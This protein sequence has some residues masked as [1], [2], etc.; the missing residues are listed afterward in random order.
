MH[1]GFYGKITS[2]LPRSKGAEKAPGE[3]L[4]SAIGKRGTR[5][6]TSHV[7]M[8]H[9]MLS[10]LGLYNHRQP[11]RVQPNIRKDETGPMG[12]RLVSSDQSFVRLEL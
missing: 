10:V 6:D 7:S 9:T 4:L 3:E 12:G 11:I 8:L 2:Q 1:G 5:N